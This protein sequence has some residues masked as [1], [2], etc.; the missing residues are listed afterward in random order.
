[1]SL[2]AGT[3]TAVFMACVSESLSCFFPPARV[4][5]VD[6][7]KCTVCIN[8]P[9]SDHHVCLRTANKTADRVP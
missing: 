8:L 5:A 6:L 2:T 4:P 9:A 7:I 3:G 1:M